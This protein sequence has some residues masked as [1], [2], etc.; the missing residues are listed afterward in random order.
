MNDRIIGEDF[1]G[2]DTFMYSSEDFE[3][4]S[5]IKIQRVSI[6]DRVDY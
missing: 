4:A 6:T 5:Y 1:S 2:K 3:G